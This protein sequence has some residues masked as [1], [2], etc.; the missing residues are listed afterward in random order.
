MPKNRLPAIDVMRGLVMIL[1]T[2]DHASDVFDG[3][4]LLTDGALMYDPAK[5]LPLGQFLTRWITHLCAPTFVLLAG[6]A[7]ALSTAS[8]IRRGD[9]PTQID[10]HMTIRGLILVAADPIW[11][12]PVILGPGRVLLQVMYALGG[13]LLL[14]IPLR[15]L[16]DRTL[17]AVGLAIA[18]LDEPALSLLNALGWRFSLPVC[19]LLGPGFF[20]GGRFVIG[21][22]VLPWLAMMCVGWV[23]GRK[24]LEWP[25]AD[26][27]RIAARTMTIAGAALLALFVLLRGLNGFGNTGLLRLDG[28][29][30]QWLHVSKYPPSL[31]YDGLE[32]GL[33]ALI[34]AALFRILAK[35]P[36]FAHPYDRSDRWPFS[37]I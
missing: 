20:A 36:D 2:I 26:R 15:R 6:T 28:S 37:T 17:L 31:T 16:G 27:D 11:M 35:R 14:M 23:F 4:H 34:L 19:L 30:V 24:L 3:G 29:L 13:S 5:P 32:L 25:E 22:P 1:M 18:V 33:A 8:R 7:L 9:S 21:Y 10:R 12:S